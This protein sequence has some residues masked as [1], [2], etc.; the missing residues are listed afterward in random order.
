MND[1]L[2][3][4]ISPM[5]ALAMEWA[6]GTLGRAERADAD[7]RRARDPEFAA[8]CDDWAEQ[9]SPL[10]DEVAPLTPSPEV[11][12]RIDSEIS[13]ETSFQPAPSASAK[14]SWWQTLGLWQ[15]ATAAFASLAL[16]LL[17]TRPPT[18]LPT[19][20]AAIAPQTSLLAATLAAEG[21]RALVTASLD[22]GRS[23]VVVSPVATENLDGRVP[24]LWLIPADGKPRSLGL[25]NLGG[26]QQ[27]AVSPTLL[28]LVAEGAVLAVS[29]E[30]AGGSPTGLP[31]G[32]VVATG[33]LTT[34]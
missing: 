32:P 24:E 9:L 13:K 4:D 7:A 10:A 26:V 21:G 33:K 29:L 19:A 6:L 22:T 17:V 12:A 25:I 16:A 34:L 15:A 27:V 3:E 2:P 8:L 30:P 5:E 31:T 18:P 23:T 20:P 11:W 28:K 14:L 1:E